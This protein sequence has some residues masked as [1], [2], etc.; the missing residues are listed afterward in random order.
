LVNSLAQ[1]CLTHL[2]EEAVHTDAYTLNTTR[3]DE[4]LLALETEFSSSFINP[5]LQTK[6]ITKAPLRAAKRS[7]IYNETV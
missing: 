2:N 5:E 1:D 4:A 7:V 3:V 6:A